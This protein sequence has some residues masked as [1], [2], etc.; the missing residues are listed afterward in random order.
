MQEARG[1]I[2][3]AARSAHVFGEPTHAKWEPARRPE[4][5]FVQSPFLHSR[6]QGSSTWREYQIASRLK[7]GIMK[8]SLV[9]MRVETR[10]TSD[11]ASSMFFALPGR[12]AVASLAGITA[13]GRLW[14]KI[15]LKV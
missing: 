3:R 5:L 14:P 2:L 15:I 11:I 8:R 4:G 12:E 1:L 13:N 7:S 9:R 10:T 6:E